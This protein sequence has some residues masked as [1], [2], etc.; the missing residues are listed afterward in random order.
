MKKIGKIARIAGM[1]AL[2]ISTSACVSSN[3]ASQ[4]AIEVQRPFVMPEPVSQ[5]LDLPYEQVAKL[6]ISR[7]GAAQLLDTPAAKE[8]VPAQMPTLVS[9]NANSDAGMLLAQPRSGFKVARVYVEVPKELTVSEANVFVPNSDIVWRE[10]PFG[11]RKE[12][13][14]KILENALTVGTAGFNGEKEVIMSVR[15]NMFHALSEKA[16]YTVGGRHNI[17]FDYVL[18]DAETGKPV[19]DVKN[20]DLKF[21]AYGG[22]RADAAVQR[23]ETQKVRISQHVAEA[24]YNQLSTSRA[25]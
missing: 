23:G 8:A 5:K 18:L 3:K 25:I 10:D 12:Q 11:D 16:R 9:K 19:S 21:R 1:L 2:A 17:N 7:T 6:E 22:R 15:V 24:V 14:K 13:V 20:V 4:N